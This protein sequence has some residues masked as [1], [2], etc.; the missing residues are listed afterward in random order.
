M[1][2]WIKKYLGEYYA[3]IAAIDLANGEY[4]QGGRALLIA[5][6]LNPYGLFYHLHS[7]Y[8]HAQVKQFDKALLHSDGAIEANDRSSGSYY[9]RAAVELSFKNFD[10]ALE[11]ANKALELSDNEKFLRHQFRVFSL[12]ARGL[13]FVGLGRLEEAKADVEE[14]FSI[15][16][17]S[18][19]GY[20]LLADIHKK[21]GEFDCAMVC[22]NKAIHKAKPVEVPDLLDDR[23]SVFEAIGD[24]DAASSDRERARRMRAAWFNDSPS[25]YI[26]KFRDEILKKPFFL[27]ICLAVVVAVPT[28][29]VSLFLVIIVGRILVKSLSGV[30]LGLCVGACLCFLSFFIP[31]HVAVPSDGKPVQIVTKTL[32]SNIFDLSDWRGKVVLLY[33]VSPSS[34]HLKQDLYKLSKFY[35]R[36]PRKKLEL[37]G[38]VNSARG[39]AFEDKNGITSVSW[40]LLR[41]YDLSPSTLKQLG[42]LGQQKFYVLSPLDQH[43]VFRCSRASDLYFS[44]MMSPRVSA[45]D[46]SK[47]TGRE[48]YELYDLPYILLIVSMLTFMAADF[49]LQKMLLSKEDLAALAMPK[50]SGAS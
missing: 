1:L 47:F 34:P 11:Y 18:L 19:Y 35:R 40:P 49:I 33:S 6:K 29:A 43:I 23:A 14:L 42:D 41:S 46:F 25:K 12:L 16:K 8:F 27:L 24:Q 26:E 32:D 7:S 4:S 36:Y 9:N 5:G 17:E 21:A 3:L 28:A 48:I 44:W 15:Q 2:S 38:I 45:A 13:S 50:I 30:M 39:E 10:S 31:K 22:F 37:V 20:V